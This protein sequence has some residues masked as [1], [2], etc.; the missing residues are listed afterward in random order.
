MENCVDSG[1]A[2]ECACDDLCGDESDC[3]VDVCS[4]TAGC[5]NYVAAADLEICGCDTAADCD[6]GLPCTIDVCDAISGCSNLTDDALCDDGDGCTV[7]VCDATAGCLNAQELGLAC[8][9]G[10]CGTGT[11]QALT[12]SGKSCTEL[13]W[14]NAFGTPDVCGESD[15]NGIPDCSGA[16]DHRDAEAICETA[17]GRLCAPQRSS[18][19]TKPQAQGV[20]TMVTGPGPRTRVTLIVI[21]RGPG[22][23]SQS[24]L[25]RGNARR[26]PNQDRSPAVVP[27]RTRPSSWLCARPRP[28][29]APMAAP[30]RRRRATPKRMSARQLTCVRGVVSRLQAVRTAPTRPMG[31]VTRPFSA[32]LLRTRQQRRVAFRA[33]RS[34]SFSRPTG[35]GG[36]EPDRRSLWQYGGLDRT[37][38]RRR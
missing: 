15:G 28:P 23:R 38:R 32:P 22:Q 11:C 37:C 6:D 10:V 3:T 9:T 7:D 36:C 4:A 19:V 14:P 17:G 2:A 26:P 24:A 16:V 29:T 31:A 27:M 34:R 8:S 21:G 30:V 12:K 35:G 5:V 33:G 1:C 18:K 13:G 25:S 20:V